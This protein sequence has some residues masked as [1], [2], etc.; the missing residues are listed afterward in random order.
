[1]ESGLENRLAY[2]K[3]TNSLTREKEVCKGT[4]NAC[5]GKNP[6][7]MVRGEIRTRGAGDATQGAVETGGL[8]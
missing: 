1:M 3:K 7:I 8:D 2:L 5:W 6:Y 4:R